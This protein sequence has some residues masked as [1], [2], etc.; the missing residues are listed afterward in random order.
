[1]YFQSWSSDAVT[2]MAD[3]ASEHRDI[4]FV[5]MRYQKLSDISSKLQAADYD[6]LVTRLDALDYREIKGHLPRCKPIVNIYPDVISKSIPSVCVIPEDSVAV[7]VKYFKGMDINRIVLFGK[8]G[9]PTFDALDRS[10]RSLCAEECFFCASKSYKFPERVFRKSIA[11]IDPEV[12]EWLAGVAVEPIGVLT[13]GGYS[14]TFLQQ[15]AVRLG[16]EPAQDVAILSITNDEICFFA[17]PP[18]SAMRS[19]IYELGTTTISVLHNTLRGG[20]HP[21]GRVALSKP[22]VIERRSTLRRN[23]PE[24]RVRLALN[25]LR[26][27]ACN[28]VTVDDAVKHAPGISRVM[29]YSIFKN[30]CGCTPGEEIRRIKMDAAKHLLRHTDLSIGEVAERAGFQSAQYFSDTFRSDH[31][32]SPNNWRRQAD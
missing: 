30:L 3:Y 14:A 10:L 17:D 15:A 21:V 13:T 6:G 31:G 20:E 28:G 1:M 5:D 32:L 29:F 7:A 23:D 25:Y 18:I 2:G 27:N 4:H 8:H 9:I 11:P 26:N 24:L 16:L 19:R 22:Q 12:D